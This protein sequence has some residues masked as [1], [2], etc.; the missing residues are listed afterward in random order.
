MVPSFHVEDPGTLSDIAL[1]E[2]CGSKNPSQLTHR[3][4][5]VRHA[6]WGRGPECLSAAAVRRQC[7]CE[8]SRTFQGQGPGPLGPTCW[9]LQH[10]TVRRWA[11][12]LTG[13]LSACRVGVCPRRLTCRL[14]A[15][16]GQAHSILRLQL[17]FF[18]CIGCRLVVLCLIYRRTIGRLVQ[19]RL[20]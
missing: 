5:D 11:T 14:A 10:M 13:G 7:Y 12:A 4:P 19:L 17:M 20:S 3:W 18:V 6:A 16:A 8:E 15:L 9:A 2:S 1:P